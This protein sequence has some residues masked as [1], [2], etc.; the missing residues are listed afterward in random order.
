M[1]C[2]PKNVWGLIIPLFLQP[3]KSFLEETFCCHAMITYSHY[4]LLLVAI[5]ISVGACIKQ[6]FPS[7]HPTNSLNLQAIEM[8]KL[9]RIVKHD[10][11]TQMEFICES[12]GVSRTKLP[13]TFDDLHLILQAFMFEWSTHFAVNVLLVREG[14]REA[15]R[16][17]C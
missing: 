2:Q 15:K 12:V 16:E 5:T 13:F 1:S 11:T 8:F 7:S 10:R 14:N 4:L 6:S 17:W 9:Y 3:S